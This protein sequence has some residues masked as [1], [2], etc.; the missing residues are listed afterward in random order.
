MRL[1]GE[2]QALAL[3]MESRL[4]ALEAMRLAGLQE[5]FDASRR[6]DWERKNSA[7]QTLLGVSLR[8]SIGQVEPWAQP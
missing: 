2:S 1:M 8:A 3:Q 6:E 5:E 7:V 4:N